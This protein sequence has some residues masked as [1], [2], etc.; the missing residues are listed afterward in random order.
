M[1]A[2]PL[3]LSSLLFNAAIRLLSDSSFLPLPF[4]FRSFLPLPYG[5]SLSATWRLV[6]W[7]TSLSISPNTRVLTDSVTII[8]YS[9][10]MKKRS[11][12]TRENPTSTG[13]G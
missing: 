4:P 6:L 13:W 5:F 3:L 7:R 11:Q 10:C 1:S 8:G 12:E 9:I 2:L